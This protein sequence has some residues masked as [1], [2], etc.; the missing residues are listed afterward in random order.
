MGIFSFKYSHINS[1]LRAVGYGNCRC[2]SRSE[3]ALRLSQVWTPSPSS[4]L[5]IE[6][7]GF[8]FRISDSDFKSSNSTFTP[9]RDIRPAPEKVQILIFLIKISQDYS[10]TKVTFFFV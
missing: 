7:L 3:R 5:T 10:K 4:R 9:G 1:S 6:R 2:R 8:E